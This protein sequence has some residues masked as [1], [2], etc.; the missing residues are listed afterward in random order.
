MPGP[1][2]T[3]ISTGVPFPSL[4]GD[5]PRPPSPR[6]K[7]L[8]YY[9]FRQQQQQQQH[10]AV[11]PETPSMSLSS[12]AEEITP[13]PMA[14]FVERVVTRNA[15]GGA[16]I[17]S[18]LVENRVRPKTPNWS[19][20]D[21]AS[22]RNGGDYQQMHSG[23]QSQQ[24][25]QHFSRPS[26]EIS[27]QQSARRRPELRKQRSNNFDEIQQQQQH[28]PVPYPMTAPAHSKSFFADQIIVASLTTNVFVGA[29]MSAGNRVIELLSPYSSPSLQD[30]SISANESLHIPPQVNDDWTICHDIAQFV[31][32]RYDRDEKDVMVSV[33]HGVCVFFQGCFSPSYML[34]LSLQ[35]GDLSPALNRRNAAILQTQLHEA[36]G[37]HPQRGIIRFDTV[38][39]DC[40]AWN[41]ATVTSMAAPNNQYEAYYHHPHHPVMASSRDAGRDRENWDTGRAR[42]RLSV[43]VC[44]ALKDS[45]SVKV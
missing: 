22:S 38:P 5:P 33:Q 42:S 3:V 11:R 43:K 13:R 44:A 1:L 12:T 29:E 32:R 20:T 26:G 31:A 14:S 40:L 15:S 45:P 37:V 25:P 9:Q 27:R 16:I 35:P 18:T 6:T 2:R 10:P 30:S 8:A 24:Q 4:E 28:Q 7:P 21:R 36:I 34:T 41:G 39:D 19:E 23:M 17:S